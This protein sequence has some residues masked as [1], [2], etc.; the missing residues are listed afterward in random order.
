MDPRTGEIL[1][2]QGAKNTAA[3]IGTPIPNSGDP[4]MGIEQAGV[5]IVNTNYKWPWLVVAPRFGFAYDV[6]GN[7]DLVLRGG[8]G[9]FYD[10]PDGNTVFSTPANPPIATLKNLYNGELATLGQGGLSLLPVPNMVTFQYEADVPSSWQWQG[11]FQKTLP[12]AMALDVMYVGNHG[13]NR[14]GA[15]QGGSRQLI[16]SVD[17]GAAYLPE[18]QDPTLGTSDGSRGKCVHDEPAASLPGSRRD[19]RERDI[20]LGYLSL[21]TDELDPAVP[22]RNLVRI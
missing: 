13:F 1:V 3:A 6:T 2:V 15:F 14:M 20:V 21:A 5:G 18:N 17:L 8:F 7:S 9:L 11:G 12:G 10:R 19:R 4:L 16:N 22:E